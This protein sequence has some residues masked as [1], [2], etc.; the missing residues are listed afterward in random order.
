VDIL[1]KAEHKRLDES[2]EDGFLADFIEWAGTKTDAPRYAL[3]TAAL[4]ALSLSCA[5]VVVLPPIFGSAPIYLNLYIMLIGPSTTM[6]KTTVLNY[7]TDL[8][9]KLLSGHYVY[10]LDDV[11]SQAFNKTVA[12]AGTEKLPVLLN[13][14]EVSGLFEVLKRKGSYLAGFDKVLMRCYDH[15]PIY[16]HRTNSSIEA[17]TGAFTAVYAASTPEPLMEALGGEDI[18]SGLLPRFLYFN[19]DG[20]DRRPRRS[21]MDRMENNDDWE[22]EGKRLAAFLRDVAHHRVN[23]FLPLVDE[24]GDPIPQDYPITTIPFTD[25]ALKRLDSI[26]AIFTEEAWEDEASWGAIKGRGFWHIV[27]LSGLYAIS[28]DG[29]KAKVELIDVLRAAA[30]VEILLEDMGKMQDEVGANATERVIKSV[31]SL[32]KQHPGGYQRQDNI[33]RQLKLTA[34]DAREL[35]RTMVMRGLITVD[36]DAQGAA[37]WRLS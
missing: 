17:E 16:V 12:K 15:T 22:A 19:I 8:L 36:K 23:S 35:M 4:M 3:Q 29:R 2:D 21:L 10:V 9:P 20:S 28:R 26:D 25:P 31:L 24:D 34:R 14:D 1:T 11:S 5:D 30:L 33:V 7:V 13:V 27:K 37:I 32:I 18:A 6:R